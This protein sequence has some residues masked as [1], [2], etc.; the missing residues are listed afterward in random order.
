VLLPMLSKQIRS[1][2]Q[3]EARTSMNR[4]LELVLLFGFPATA[5]LMVIAEPI[6]RVLYQHGAF[7]PA[8]MLQATPT[9]VAFTA[10]LPAFL[11]VK[12]FAP[13]FYANHDTKTPFKIAMVCVAVNLFFNLTLSRPFAQV[14]MAAATSIA[15]W[16]NVASMVWILH[17][18]GIFA[19]DAL[20][21]SRLRK[22]LIAS[23][24]MAFALYFVNR[25]FTDYY[26]GGMV[27]KTLGLLIVIGAGTGVY[28]IAVLALRA[29]DISM[30]KRL[31]RTRTV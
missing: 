15:G 8:D 7:T 22:L 11:A 30:L 14:G 16:V 20:L 13:G 10:G 28:A 27:M 23:A 5:A 9:L 26:S 17:K 2:Q 29:Y 6:I 25:Y 31:R 12:I 21:K 18:R 19:P 24:V 3:A 4:A 1:G